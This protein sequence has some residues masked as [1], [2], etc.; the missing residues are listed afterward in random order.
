MKRKF[1][2]ITIIGLLIG[3]GVV[4][5]FG[6]NFEIRNLH[7]LNS[8]S[9]QNID[10]ARDIFKYH[11]IYKNDTSKEAICLTPT[12]V[13]DYWIS[14][15][16]GYTENA[17]G[18]TAGGNITMMIELT[19]VELANYRSCDVDE[20]YVSIGCDVV[21]G[22]SCDYE[23]F[24]QTSMPNYNDVYTGGVNIVAA[25]TS[26]DAVWQY[27]NFADFPIP[28]T[29]SVFVGVTFWNTLAGQYP[30]G[31]DESN[32]GPT[33]RANYMTYDGFGK[34]SNLVEI[35]YPEVWGLDVGVKCDGNQPPN[36][37]NTP[38]PDN[39][40]TGID[41]NTDISWTGGDPD[42]G[43]TVIYDIYF[44][45]N[46]NPPLKKSDHTSTNYD[47]GTM[48]PSTKYYWKIV[49]KDN[50]GATTP[51]PIWDFTTRGSG[52]QSPE[53]DAGGPYSGNVGIDILFDGSDS[54]DNDENGCCIIQY[55]WKFY[56]GGNWLN[57]IGSTPTYSYTEEGNFIVTLRVHDNEGE[58]DTDTAVASI[59][60]VSDK[61][62]AEI[63]DVSPE[64]A[65]VKHPTGLNGKNDPIN[66]KGNGIPSHGKTITEYIWMYDGERIPDSN[67]KEFSTPD[68]PVGTYTISLIVTDNE[69]LQSEEVFWDSDIIIVDGLV[70][71]HPFENIPGQVQRGTRFYNINNDALIEDT[72][73]DG[74]L[75]AKTCRNKDRGDVY[76]YSYGDTGFD[77]LFQSCYAQAGQFVS[78]NADSSTEYISLSAKFHTIGGAVDDFPWGIATTSCGF[79]V[80]K[81]VLNTGPIWWEMNSDKEY[82]DPPCGPLDI[83]TSMFGP[84]TSLLNIPVKITTIIGLIVAMSSASIDI[85][86]YYQMLDL[87]EKKDSYNVFNYNVDRIKITNPNRDHALLVY[88]GSGF[89]GVWIGVGEACRIG[90][91][92][93]I[94]IRKAGPPDNSC[95]PAGTRITMADGS[96][97]NIEDINIG[98]EIL[99]YNPQDKDFSSWKVKVLERPIVHIYDINN[100]LIKT[101]R[102]HPFYI[103]KKDGRVGWGAIKPLQDAFRIKDDILQIEIG[104]K[105]LKSDGSWI[106]INDIRFDPNPVQT[107]NIL[108]YLGDKNYFANDLLVYEDYQTLSY[109]IKEAF[110]TSSSPIR[111]LINFFKQHNYQ[112]FQ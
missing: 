50:H 16:D 43:D 112:F 81:T 38:N 6:N 85:F 111:Y 49:A 102:D 57:D 98:D 7:K 51:G 24:V 53:A 80:Y 79:R 77:H 68:L 28:D 110:R 63:V 100:G 27:I 5:G 25:G 99:S 106:T 32:T 18:L 62:V 70:F 67:K 33:P 101:S 4:S 36:M 14:Y 46:S 41:I 20:I 56:E 61:P 74:K 72:D 40:A 17:L 71:R 52:T 83:L 64:I 34:W 87:L 44:G 82:I 108:S 94:I 8:F 23:V 66:F 37:P 19:D 2:V 109:L 22:H 21:G 97:K 39:H 69:G 12:L 65:G 75:I 10:S 104:D 58:I 103:K 88:M 89:S 47:P 105:L 54:Y 91:I 96:Y 76:V 30:C 78:F 48:N 86:N 95:F 73:G 45:T 107:Y 15:N 42:S 35:G 90:L 13:S 59:T 93:H 55:D 3:T 1:L 60:S 11:S 26:T 92:E 9:L 31:M 84:I 29:G